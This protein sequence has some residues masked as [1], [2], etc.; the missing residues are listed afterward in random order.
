MTNTDEKFQHPPAAHENYQSDYK[1]K[2]MN[3]QQVHFKLGDD[4]STYTVSGKMRDHTLAGHEPGRLREGCKGRGSPFIP[5]WLLMLPTHLSAKPV[6]DTT[7][8][9]HIS[10]GRD[11]VEY[12][13]TTKR[14][15]QRQPG[16]FKPLRIHSNSL[17]KT[18]I[19]LGDGKTNKERAT[20]CLVRFLN[21]H[22]EST[23]QTRSGR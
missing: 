2:G 23:R 15:Y 4:K 9:V 20:L 22:Y 11:K 17:A 21:A 12:E 3:L 18:H 16:D 5:L 14:F 7:Q 6:K 10:F 13:P 8:R 19:V 1:N